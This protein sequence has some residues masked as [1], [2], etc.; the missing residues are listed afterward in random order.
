MPPKVVYTNSKNLASNSKKAYRKASK[1]R[2]FKKGS[3]NMSFPKTNQRRSYKR[4]SYRSASNKSKK[5]AL[6]DIENGEI[7]VLP[8]DYFRKLRSGEIEKKSYEFLQTTPYLCF[9]DNSDMQCSKSFT[10]IIQKTE[11]IFFSYIENEGDK[12][13]LLIGEGLFNKDDDE[14]MF[15]DKLDAYFEKNKKEI[16][17]RFFFENWGY[18]SKQPHPFSNYRIHK[19][20]YHFISKN[21]NISNIHF[22]NPLS[23]YSELTEFMKLRQG[24]MTEQKYNE[25]EAEAPKTVNIEEIYIEYIQNNKKINDAIKGIEDKYKEKFSEKEIKFF[26]DEATRGEASDYWLYLFYVASFSNSLY[27]AAQILNKNH[28]YNVIYG[29]MLHV[30][31]IGMIL[32]KVFEYEDN[33]PIRLTDLK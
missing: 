11:N 30:E 5:S 32:G 27:T 10:S 28:P 25:Y 4:R 8:N 7:V 23:K 6:V 15:I 22:E 26:F 19:L 21:D 12:R 17:I 20:P 13:C 2:S 29:T 31:I 3:R 33:I 9:R 24:E 16:N 1:R 14:N 18:S